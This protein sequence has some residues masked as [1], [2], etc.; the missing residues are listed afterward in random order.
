MDAVFLLAFTGLSVG[1]LYFL[2]ASGLGLIFGLM[3]VLSFAHGAYLGVC[4]YAGWLILRGAD[5]AVGA[6]T[7][8][9]VLAGLVAVV[10]GGLLAYLT[11]VFLIR[12]LYARAH[13]DQ[14]LVTMGLGFILVAVVSGVWG[15][16]EISVPLPQWVKHTTDVAGSAVPTDRF[17]LIAAAVVVYLAIQVFLRRTRHGLIVRAG[18]ENRDMVRA[19]GIDVRRSFTL[20]FVLGGMAAGLGGVLAA[21]YARAITPH[22]GDTFLLYAFIVLIIGGLGSLSG[23]LVAAAVIG[24][25]QQFANYYIDP[26]LGDILAVGLMAVM[27]LV[28]PQ[29]LFGRRE[30][31][32]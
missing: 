30:R 8:R 23:A 9:L 6:P 1:A 25:L 14:L 5:Y 11:E 21:V 22:L 17:I 26:G 29:G 16:D 13:L 3:N 28:R 19:L 31:L 24:L 4:A 7:W 18:V 10:V 15:P 20:V 27:L 12:P 32:V 2:L